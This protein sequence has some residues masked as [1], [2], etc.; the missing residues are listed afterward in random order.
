MT[1]NI[2]FSLIS[3]CIRSISDMLISFAESEGI[4]SRMALNEESSDFP[5]LFV[6]EMT[7]GGLLKKDK[8]VFPSAMIKFSD[9]ALLPCLLQLLI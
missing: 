9:Q 3:D 5:G 1:G 4:S 2:G 6:E 7:D 8:S